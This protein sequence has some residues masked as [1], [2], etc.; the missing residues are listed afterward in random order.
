[1]F[2]FQ[3]GR[4]EDQIDIIPYLAIYFHK[5]FMNDTDEK[6]HFHI[7]IQWICWWIEIQIGKDFIVE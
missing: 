1:M 7:V 3:Y 4:N 5:H 2:Q 6:W